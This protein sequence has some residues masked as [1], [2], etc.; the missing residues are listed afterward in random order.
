MYT[1]IYVIYYVKDLNLSN[2]LINPLYRSGICYLPKYWSENTSSET[3]GYTFEIL[4]YY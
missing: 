1:I 4:T 2:Q 3:Q